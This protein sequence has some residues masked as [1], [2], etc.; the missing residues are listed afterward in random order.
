MGLLKHVQP[1]AWEGQNRINL[2]QTFAPWASERCEGVCAVDTVCCCVQAT[3]K[4]HAILC[5]VSEEN[6]LS[7]CR[8]FVASSTLE[9][10][11]EQPA[12]ADATVP[13]TSFE[14]MY[15]KMGVVLLGT[16]CDG[17]CGIDVACQMLSLPQT[18]EHR[19]TLREEISDYLIQRIEEPWMHDLMVLCEELSANDVAQFRSC[20]AIIIPDT[21]SSRVAAA[22]ADAN[23]AA[24]VAD[25]A[26][27]PNTSLVEPTVDAPSNLPDALSSL[28]WATN[29][30]DH[31]VLCGLAAALPPQIVKEQILAFD[32]HLRTPKQSVVENDQIQVRPKIKASRDKVASAFNEFL[33][34]H[35][36]ALTR[37][38][39]LRRGLMD[40]FITEKLDANSAVDKRHLAR[41]FQAWKQNRTPVGETAVA[42]TDT[43]E[44]GNQKPNQNRRRLGQVEEYKRRNND[45][46][47][48]RPHHCVLVRQALYDWFVGLR[49]A[50]NWDKLAEMQHTRKVLARFP[51]SVLVTKVKQL[52]QDYCSECLLRGIK[53]VTFEP[54][55]RW[56]KSWEA[57]YGLSMRRPN[58]KFKVPKHVLAERLELWWLS[59]ARVRKLAT[60]ILGYDLQM[61]NWDQSPYH[62]NEVGSQDKAVLAVAG[63]EV[64]IIEGHS[65]VRERWTA[66]LTTF[67][68]KE[69][70]LRDGPPYAELMF[71]AAADG[72]VVLRLVEYV[73][74]RGY[75]TWFSVTTAPKGSYREADILQF[76]ERHLPLMTPDREWRIIMGDDFG[77]HKTDNVRRL[78]WKRGYVLIIHGGGA[79]PVAQTP[80]TDLNEH[81]RRDYSAKESIE[82]INQM[83]DGVPVPRLKHEQAIDLMYDVLSDTTLH[84]RAAEGFKYT[85]ATV[86][87][88]G[89]EDA[90]IVRE[91]GKFWNELDM[92]TKVN[93][94]LQIVEEEVLAQRLQWT[95]RD[96]YRLIAPYPKRGDVDA[97]IARV[98]ED[99]GG[100]DLDGNAEGASDAGSETDDGSEP[101]ADLNS[102]G[103]VVDA[104]AAVADDA[105]ADA[106]AAP[107]PSTRVV[108]QCSAIEAE[109]YHG[110]LTK[111]TALT[112]SI[113]ALKTCGAIRAAV[114]LENELKK[115]TRRKRALCKESPA[116]AEA[117]A[118]SRAAEETENRRKRQLAAEA[119]ENELRAGK[120]R[121]QME[122]TKASLR[123]KKE[124]LL[125]LENLI[126]T[127]HAMKSYTVESLSGPQSRK[128]RFEVLDRLARTGPGLTAEQK[129]D[130]SW[131]KAAWDQKMQAEHKGQWGETFATWVQHVLNEIDAGHASAFSTFVYNETC[132]CFNTVPAL[133]LP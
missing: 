100:G 121:K 39:K 66:N 1:Y 58:R 97:V 55:S 18:F 78:C 72:T 53:P 2:V 70:I 3:P 127:K 44:T 91:A 12:V 107:L 22:V 77:P 42:A 105:V 85:G 129:N 118:R 98:G 112:E 38:G 128:R 96:V 47:Q 63:T 62:N 19:R 83:R 119:N 6:P 64:P 132:R 76:L 57:D 126:E 13:S 11:H 116:V 16:V 46:G 31:G 111:V 106:A 125:A 88:D 67:S 60:L 28:R 21:G 102:A 84:L 120:L 15:E 59:L 33:V 71:K 113:H 51:R 65:D 89:S 52:L 45:G 131:F 133:T 54:R 49:Y 56:F 23:S 32:A 4:G 10:V 25:A 95:R 114:A 90:L 8:H 82:L 5:A 35:G 124:E 68:D 93:Q 40:H 94:Q 122:E 108:A 81:V 9:V 80:D 73:R 75:S 24:A 17:D 7:E 34:E 61:E 14:G 117:L 29:V 37:Q 69:R 79:T 99:A 43:Q 36:V 123:Q 41:W 92:R 103:A 115:E 74:S 48:G 110:V 87:L 130:W 104:D 30:R 26:L 109:K 50:V 86:A 20:G 101:V 27:E